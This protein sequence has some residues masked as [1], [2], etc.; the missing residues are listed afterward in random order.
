MHMW[1][2]LDI[3]GLGDRSDCRGPAAFSGKAKNIMDGV[4]WHQIIFNKKP[5]YIVKKKSIREKFKKRVES[6]KFWGDT[7]FPQK[8]APVP[9]RSVGYKYV[10][11]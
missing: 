8:Q 5:K 6:S 7:Y 10:M 3:F 9:C 1:F 4:A 2:F 11:L